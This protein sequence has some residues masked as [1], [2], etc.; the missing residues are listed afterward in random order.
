MCWRLAAA[1]GGSPSAE[2]RSYVN[3]V[4]GK[5]E[6]AT[7]TEVQGWELTQFDFGADK[8][9]IF[10]QSGRPV[11]SV[12]GGGPARSIYIEGQRIGSDQVTVEIA[13]DHSVKE[14]SFFADGV[15]YK[16]R[17]SEAGWVLDKHRR[18]EAAGP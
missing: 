5:P 2:K 16:L 3:P 14:I 12:V 6:V 15:L 7:V 13:Q 17:E 10:G 1:C 18:K 8:Y 9:V 4:T 11:V